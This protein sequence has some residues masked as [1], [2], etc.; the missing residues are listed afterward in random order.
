V[1]A[2]LDDLVKKYGVAAIRL[3]GQGVGT[4]AP[5]ATNET[6]EGKKLNRQVKLVAK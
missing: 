3:S 4:L 2:E 5:V 1:D 6:D